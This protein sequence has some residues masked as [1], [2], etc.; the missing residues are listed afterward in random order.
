MIYDLLFSSSLVRCCCGWCALSS[1]RFTNKC[2][3][4]EI[5]IFDY[6]TIRAATVRDMISCESLKRAQRRFVQMANVP[7]MA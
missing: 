6:Y 5:I 7:R 2:F 1:R 3:L 4:L